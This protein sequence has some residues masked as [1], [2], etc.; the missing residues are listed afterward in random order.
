[1]VRTQYVCIDKSKI[2]RYRFYMKPEQ[3]ASSAAKKAI[4]V[5]DGLGASANYVIE[6][7]RILFRGF[8][9]GR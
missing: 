1:M 2:K 6:L 9:K 5:S 4:E 3:I 8:T 7:V